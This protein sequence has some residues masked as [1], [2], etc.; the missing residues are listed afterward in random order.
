[1]SILP[2]G[3]VPAAPIPNNVTPV[4]PTK[5]RDGDGDTDGTRALAAAQQSTPATSDRRLDILT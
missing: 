3:Q 1:M 4:R 5:S 2:A